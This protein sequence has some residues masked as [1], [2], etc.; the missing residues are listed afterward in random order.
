M[1]IR[2]F[3]LTIAV[4][5]DYKMPISADRI[6]EMLRDHAE[7]CDLEECAFEVKGGDGK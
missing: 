7:S 2:E 3:T 1:K 4:P 5:D 6:V